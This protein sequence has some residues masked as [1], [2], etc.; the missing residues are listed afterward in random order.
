[1]YGSTKASQQVLTAFQCIS[2]DHLLI[3][4]VD[5]ETLREIAARSDVIIPPEDEEHYRYLLDSFDATAQQVADLPAYTN[6]ELLPDPTT[7]PRKFWKEQNN[8][9][10]AWSH[11]TNII[12][13]SPTSDTLSGRTVAI[14]DNIS[15]SAIP[16]TVGTF[17]ELLVGKSEFPTSEIDAVVVSR[18]LSA[19]GQITGS[20]T[21]EHFSLTPL[22]YTSASGPVHNPWKKGWT[23]G[24]S[25]SG[26]AALVG[27]SQIREWRKRH[28][29]P[30]NE[31]Q[32]GPGVDMAIG[33]DQG[34]S[35]RIPAAYCGI[36]GLKPT[37]GLVPYT[38]I[39]SL[40]PLID[41]TGPIAK[42]IQDIAKLLGVIAGYD[43]FD[44]RMTPE[45]PRRNEVNDYHNILSSWI[46]EKK[47]NLEW[48][49]ESAG[50][51][52]KIGV[53]K[54][55]FQ[56]L[57]LSD[58]VKRIVS[59]AIERFKA[60][61][62]TVEEVSIPMHLIGPAIWTI[63]TRIPMATQGFQNRSLPMLCP[64]LPGISPPPFSQKAYEIL[65]KH[66]PAVVNVIFNS[67]FLLHNQEPDLQAKAMMHVYQLRA[68]YDDALTKYDVLITPLNS[69]LGSKH[70]T[71]EM[72]VQ[73]KTAPSIG[74]TL[75]T[76]QFNCTGRE[77]SKRELISSEKS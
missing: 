75:N 38:G 41:H 72:N 7:L 74:A 12:S 62:A 25:S 49:P 31:D 11:R 54:E 14:K 32:L 37:Y 26:P 59:A 39:F 23:A 73:E 51:G 19:G 34:G 70:P 24:G 65:T 44:P 46:K 10:N 67:T 71:Y 22:S 3:A 2:F 68:A 5:T 69:K 8:P 36:Y 4:V 56:V 40:C 17:P 1:L 30:Y 53:I 57:G 27:V 18:I 15:I 13:N 6:P 16:I 76:C 20:A 64:P 63:A 58:E 47:Q 50:R 43:G 61:G 35:I 21:C 66:N 48:T 29:L 9:L 42:S 28:G 77:Y 55:S 45:S 33:G 60:I 52:F